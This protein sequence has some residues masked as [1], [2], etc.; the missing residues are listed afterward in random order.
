[1]KREQ[2]E[3]VLRAAAAITNRRVF[4]VVGSQALLASH[5]NMKPPLNFSIF[6]RCLGG[7]QAGGWTR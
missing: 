4:V 2:M 3:H 6:R 1:M 5:P 7:L